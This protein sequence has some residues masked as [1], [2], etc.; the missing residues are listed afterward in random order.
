MQM[1]Y[2]LTKGLLWIYPHKPT[3]RKLPSLALQT[4]TFSR[5]D[6]G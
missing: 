6:G 3:F 2:V 1:I 5:G 4:L